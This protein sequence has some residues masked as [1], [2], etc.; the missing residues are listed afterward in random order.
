MRGGAVGT[1]VLRNV[2]LRSD[3]LKMFDR[4]WNETWMAMEMGPDV[5]LFGCLYYRQL[6]PSTLMKNALALWQSDQ[7]H[8]KKA[9]HTIDSF[10]NQN[11]AT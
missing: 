7:A 10:Q 1:N 4:A 6:E 2:E 8:P 11:S 5:A 9:R 3:N